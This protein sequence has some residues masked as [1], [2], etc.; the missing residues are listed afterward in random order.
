[1]PVMETDLEQLFKTVEKL[2]PDDLELL[3][4]RIEQSRRQK[5]SSPRGYPEE[6]AEFF[7]IPFE[8]YLSLSEDERDA[9]AF[10]AY[11]IL[12]RW[13]DEELKARHSQWML[14]CGGEIL[15]SSPKLIEYPSADK[16]M[17]IGKQRGLIP[18]V[19]IRTPL[20]EESSWSVLPELDYYP[21]LPITVGRFGATVEK[22][23][24]EG[25]TIDADLDTGS[26]YIMLDYEQMVSNG[27]IGALPIKQAHYG[28]HLGEFYQSYLLP[29]AIGVT[30][31]DGKTITTDCG[32]FLVR[33][34]RQSPLCLTNPTREAL[35]GRNVL[36]EFP[37][38]IELDGEKKTT[39]VVSKRTGTKKSK[40]H[41][42]A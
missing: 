35:V 21:T 17:A 3:Q 24:L 27:V 34:W 10:R 23:T 36:I 38:R 11:K 4:K 19:F 28:Q 20:I 12:D 9:V 1:M 14:V 31:E 7:A 42:G 40:K 13:I 6:A 33:N 2:D 8:K 39:R 25:V 29:I 37:L 32:A 22:L 18:F 41:K 16:L 5:T 30:D 26:P 15:D